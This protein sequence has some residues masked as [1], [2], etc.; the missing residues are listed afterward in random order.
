MHVGS[1]PCCCGNSRL[2]LWNEGER[3]FRGGSTHNGKV[4]PHYNDVVYY[5]FTPIRDNEGNIRGGSTSIKSGPHVK[6][7]RADLKNPPPGL[8]VLELDSS[9]IDPYQYLNLR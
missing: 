4:Y 8:R 6:F 9:G 5:K 7:T 2:L 1:A 3:N